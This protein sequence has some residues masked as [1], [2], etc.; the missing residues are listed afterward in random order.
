[1]KIVR[2]PKAMLAAGLEARLARVAE[3]GGT[4]VPAPVSASEGELQGHVPEGP[5]DRAGVRK[6]DIVVRLGERPVAGND[7]LIRTLTAETVGQRVELA[8][9]R[10]GELT[11][12]T[13]I[14]DERRNSS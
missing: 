4:P 1:M 5:A 7:D 11:K 8:V 3:M 13:V 12:L 6:G 9:L 14:P 2:I 10:A